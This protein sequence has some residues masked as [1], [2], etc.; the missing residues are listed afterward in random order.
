M[1]F[2]EGLLW[3]RSRKGRVG[4]S[5]PE[6]DVPRAEL[7]EDLVG[8]KPALPELSEVDVVRHYTKLSTWNFGVD[9]GTYPLGSCTMKYNPKIN[10]RLA[11]LPGFA[12]LHP[13]TP[14][15]CAQ[16]ALKL[17]YE[18]ER[19]LLEITKM[20]AASL[21][22]A[23]GAQGELTGI[24]MIHAYHAH[25]GRQRRKIIMPSTAHGTNPASA[26]LCGYSPVPVQL[27]PDGIMTPE[28]IREIVDEDT[29]GIMVTNPN[30]LGIF[31]SHIAEIAKIVHEKGGL[32][33]GD[34]ANLNALMG[35]ADI[36][37]MG[38][39]VLHINVHKTLSTPHGGGGPGAGPVVVRDILEPFLPVPRIIKNGDRYDLVSNAPLSIGRLHSFYGNFA[40]LARALAYTRSLGK[41]LKDVTESA[42][43]NAN[44]IKARLKGIYNLPFPQPSMHECVFND[45]L[46]HKQGVTTLDIAK[47]L[48]DLGYHPPTIYF[49]LVVDGALM[50]EPT[51]SESKADLDGFVAAMKAIAEETAADPDA[52]KSAPRNTRISRPDEVQAARH[53]VLRGDIF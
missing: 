17:M 31:E 12:N 22:P 32:V 50:I 14:E 18:L 51:E 4:M 11:G 45:A 2:K 23:A 28:A 42:V 10:E 39:D 41:H 24:L 20:H 7:A 25:K 29:A 9:T 34:G 5:L 8:E 52:V 40:T 33:Y 27:S 3:E 6:Q 37:K 48:I 46:Q 49:P 44:Y 53:P 47:R 43:L 36:E 19:D 35:Y 30:T 13:L 1:V 16:G 26:A 21:Q 15:S 38:I